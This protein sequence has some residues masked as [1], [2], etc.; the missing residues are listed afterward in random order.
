MKGRM[1]VMVKIKVKEQ[2][3][4]VRDGDP[5]VSTTKVETP[6]PW[7]ST[8]ATLAL[9][10]KVRVWHPCPDENVGVA[11]PGLRTGRGI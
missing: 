2:K 5:K 4:S 7:R 9:E 8:H 11:V 1:D 6:K 10:G 3:W